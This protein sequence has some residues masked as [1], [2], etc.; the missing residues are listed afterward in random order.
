M[1]IR[2]VDKRFGAEAKRMI[3][4][5][6]HIITE[7]TQKGYSLT[8]RQIYYQFVARGWLE[9]DILQYNRLGSV[10]SNG[11]LAGLISWHAIEDR[12]R[13]LKGVRTFSGPGELLSEA[14]RDYAMDLWR[15]QL[16]RP[17]VWV[18]KEALAGVVA[19][20]CSRLRIDFFA[21]RGYNSQSE[22][23]AAGQRF[24]NYIMKGQQPIVFHLGDHDPSGIDMTRDNRERLEMFAG[25]P[26]MV[27]RLGLNWSQIQQYE[28]PPNPAKMSDSRAEVYVK[29]F[30]DQSWELDAL[31]PE[32]ISNLIESN[33][34]KLRDEKKWS[35]ALAEEAEDKDAIDRIIEDFSGQE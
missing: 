34:A 28:P 5:A 30:G 12:T 4:Q 9:N 3:M 13:N 21:C 33:V 8:L 31:S 17:E 27:V 26:I 16:Y 24:H 2:Y 35:A 14:R 1:L 6:N 10:I 23:W 25:T 20:I 29:Q 7:Y 22:Q 11:R 18:E 19:S 32:I 15:D